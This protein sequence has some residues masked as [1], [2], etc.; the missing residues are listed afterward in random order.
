MGFSISKALVFSFLLEGVDDVEGAE[1]YTLGCEEE[2]DSAR[3]AAPWAELE[4]GVGYAAALRTGVE[5]DAA[6]GV[7]VAG[8]E[9]PLEEGVMRVDWPMPPPVVKAG[10]VMKSFAILN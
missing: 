4:A 8:V 3:A 10:S 1:E 9:E 7:G 5:E 2:V 6:L